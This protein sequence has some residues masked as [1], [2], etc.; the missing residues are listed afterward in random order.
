MT[1]RP[2]IAEHIRKLPTPREAL[3]AA[4]H[5]RGQQ[6]KDWHDVNISKMEEVLA[7]KFSPGTALAETLLQTGDRDILEDSPVCS[8]HPRFCAP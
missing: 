1:T 3:R 5:Y 2:D 4:T 6:R 7:L 8:L